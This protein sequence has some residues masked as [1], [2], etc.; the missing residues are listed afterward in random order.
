M[1][2]FNFDPTGIFN[3]AVPVWNAGTGSF[4]VG[5]AAAAPKVIYLAN[6]DTLADL[7][8]G[9]VDGQIG[10]VRIGEEPDDA[11][12]RMRWRQA[13]LKWIGAE[14][15]MAS[16]NDAWAIDGINQQPADFQ[17][18]WYRPIH[19]VG[20]YRNGV[21]AV[22][23]TN[24]TASATS[25]VA[26]HLKG[27][28]FPSEG[29]LMIRGW[30]PAY[31]GI[32]DNMD[33]TFTF[34]GVTGGPSVNLTADYVP[35]IPYDSEFGGDPGGW[36][37]TTR[38]IDHAAELWTAGF[39][40]Q[41]RVPLFYANGSQDNQAMDATLWWFNHDPNDDVFTTPSPFDEPTGALGKSITV[42]GPAESL[43][44]F[45][46]DGVRNDE[47]GFR[48]ITAYQSWVTW[49]AGTPTKR[50]LKP[51]LYHRM[52]LGALDT[53]EMYNLH[54]SLRWTGTP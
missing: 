9:D 24:Y 26:S 37:V 22:L 50:Y 54:W 45:D 40:L 6:G 42:V 21:S 29:L 43:S 46:G 27:G 53:G 10:I 32:T 15:E 8:N 1:T 12:I 38:I 30:T 39:R 20:W 25:I 31:T 11:E 13:S 16:I 52:P 36:G 48:T 35:I 44:D 51:Y 2:T 18:K 4:V 33:G 23:E 17:N 7:G 28:T 3:G 34:T 19:G 41:E 14:M 5:P 47:R 49:T